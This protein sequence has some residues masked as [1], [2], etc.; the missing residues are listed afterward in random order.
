MKW[1]TYSWWK[2]LF[3]DLKGWRHF[4]CRVNKHRC[5]VVWFSWGDEPD[6]RCRNCGEDLG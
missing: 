3:T 1:F 2:Y 4:W 6:M 5:G